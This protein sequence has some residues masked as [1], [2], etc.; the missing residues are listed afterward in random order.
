MEPTLPSSEPLLSKK[1]SWYLF[2]PGNSLAFSSLPSHDIICR[3]HTHGIR[4]G[5]FPAVV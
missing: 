5:A 1:S 4:N 2:L 3:A